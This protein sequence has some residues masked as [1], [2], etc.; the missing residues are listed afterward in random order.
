M[1]LFLRSLGQYKQLMLF[2]THINELSNW[3]CWSKNFAAKSNSLS[4]KL[5]ILGEIK[6]VNTIFQGESRQRTL[7][8]RSG[9]VWLDRSMPLWSLH[10]LEGMF[11]KST[12][13]KKSELPIVSKASYCFWQANATN[14]AVLERRNR[15]R[16]IDWH[17][18]L[19]SNRTKYNH[20][21]A[22]AD[23]EKKEKGR[24][25]N[26]FKGPQEAK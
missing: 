1:R 19:D 25:E 4:I 26:S 11:S 14:F 12:K 13:Q 24:V 22:I 16:I 10:S 3:N 7:W 20:C 5:G 21:L 2:L 8:N 15:N 18:W 9:H 6:T 23:N 17:G